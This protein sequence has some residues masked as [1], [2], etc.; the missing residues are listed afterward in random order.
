MRHLDFV[1]FSYALFTFD[2]KAKSLLIKDSYGGR[3][4]CGLM[5]SGVGLRPRLLA[6]TWGSYPSEGMNMCLL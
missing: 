1:F 4:F 3:A 2:L 6:A 5:V